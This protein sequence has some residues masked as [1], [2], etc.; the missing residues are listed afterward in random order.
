MDTRQFYMGCCA[1][2]ASLSK[3]VIAAMPEEG[4]DRRPEPKAR[5]ARELIGHI[6]GHEQ[7]L[8]ELIDDGVIHHRNV[9]EFDTLEQA[10]QLYDDAHTQ[11]EQKLGTMSDE[12]WGQTAK[13]WAGDHLALESSAGKIMWGFLFDQIHHRGQLSTYIRPAGGK[14]PGIYGPSADDS[15][16]A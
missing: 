7:D 10:L 9:V 15:G 1:H 8:V 13:M 14:V 12:A 3:K 4:L 5:T 2:E 11:L 16:H 6:I